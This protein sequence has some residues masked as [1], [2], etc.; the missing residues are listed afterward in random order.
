MM[1]LILVCVDK[2]SKMAHFIAAVTTI[3]VEESSR[4]VIDFVYKHHGLPRKLVSDR[5]TRFTS[6]FLVALC[7]ILDIK[8]AMSTTFHPQIDGQTERVNMIL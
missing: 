7:D 6:R 5:D 1:Q 2:L 3:T 8:Q 4:L